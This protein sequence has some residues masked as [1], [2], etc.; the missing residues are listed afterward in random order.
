MVWNLLPAT[1]L[2]LGVSLLKVIFSA[3]CGLFGGL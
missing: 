2:F 3:V 1:L